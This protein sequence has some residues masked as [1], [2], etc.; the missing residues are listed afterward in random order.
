MRGLSLVAVT[1]GYCSC[2][3]Q[4]SHR[5]GFSCCR[6]QALARGLRGC[7]TWALLL[8]GMWDLPRPGIEP[9]SPSLAGSFL[10]TGPPGKPCL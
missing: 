4:A 8:G 6:T 7:G 3:A 2:G 5:G 10:T 1:R 9:L